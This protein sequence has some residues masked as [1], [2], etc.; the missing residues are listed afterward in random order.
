[1]AQTIRVEPNATT[2][3]AQ[4]SAPNTALARLLNPVDNQAFECGEQAGWNIECLRSRYQ[5]TPGHWPKPV[6][7]EGKAWK[8]MAPVP[9]VQP[10]AD[11]KAEA[12]RALGAVLF[13][14]PGLS[15][16]GAVSCASCHQA[17]KAFTDGLAQ[18]VGEDKLM[19]R[20]RAQT[21]FCA[22]FSE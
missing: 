12:Q 11:A 8:E 3:L 20:R 6:I 19:G 13:F 21:L 5:G 15:R 14:D 18:R 16:K 2:K 1:M 17:D 9:A 10:P 7:D 4:A 22:P